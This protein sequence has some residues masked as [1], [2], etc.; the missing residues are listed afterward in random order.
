[1]GEG[2][3]PNENSWFDI[4]TYNITIANEN[5]FDNVIG[6]YNWFRIKHTPASNNTGSLDK[7]LY[8]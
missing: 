1:L 5:E 3:N 6:K 2:G 8:R 7:V 4:K